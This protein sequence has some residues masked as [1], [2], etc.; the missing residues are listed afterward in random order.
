GRPAM[1]CRSSSLW[2]TLM[3]QSRIATSYRRTH[4]P[5]RLSLSRHGD[6]PPR[7]R[8]SG[9]RWR[10][11]CGTVPA[12]RS[13]RPLAFGPVYS[14]GENVLGP[15]HDKM[16]RSDQETER[17]SDQRTDLTNFIWSVTDLLRAITSSR[18]TAG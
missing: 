7:P 8:A 3:R 4:R 17:I 6:W 9:A 5:D 18:S 13:P 15:Q 16:G 12:S 1:H 11:P 14:P 2:N 10:T